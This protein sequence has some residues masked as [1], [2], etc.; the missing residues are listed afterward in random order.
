LLAL[1]AGGALVVTACAVGGSSGSSGSSGTSSGN[2]T[3]SSC[4]T[5]NSAVLTNR[6]VPAALDPSTVYPPTGTV[7]KNNTADT[8]GA[9]NALVAT[10]MSQISVS[11]AEAKAI[12]EKHL[13]AVFLDWSNVTYN[14]A[15]DSGIEQELKALGV[16]LIRITDSEFSSTGLA[17]NLAAVLPLNPN[18]VLV[19]GTINPSQ[20][21]SILQPAVA[22][23]KTIV[24]WGDAGPG[25]V[26]SKDGP[27]NGLVAY[28]WYYLGEQMAKAVHEA[29]PNGA[30][31]GY[32]HWINDTDAILLREQG[33]LD[34]LKQYPNIKVVAAGGEANPKSANSGFSDPNG[35]EAYTEAFLQAHPSV[36]VIFAPWENPPGLGEEAAI[37]ALHLQG[38]VSIVT[39]DLAEAGAASL[40]DN[41][42][43]KVDMAE[44]VYDGGRMMALTA[45]LSAA[46]QPYSPF[47]NF[48][49]FAATPQ[50][51]KTAWDFMHGPQ[52]PCA[53]SIC[54]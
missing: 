23:K 11:K 33:F 19:G 29:Y 50:N 36:N 20:M 18:I 22:A 16:K 32:I 6:A 45:A 26:I 34:G 49:T 24:S 53:A 3:S 7:A 46:K 37:K 40:K 52:Y 28:D 14:K 13:T 39:M 31:L 43:I 5:Y 51:V 42:I 12:C 44:D 17:G 27:L 30:N 2:A 48:P 25:L 35:S 41:G 10:Q 38:K 47:V 9:P 54:G 4:D 8:M 1:G 21:S 15:I